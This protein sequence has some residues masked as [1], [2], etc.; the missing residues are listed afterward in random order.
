MLIG[1]QAIVLHTF[2]YGDSS[3]VARMYTRQR[4]LVSFLINGVRSKKGGNKAALLQPLS[5]LE[6][7]MQLK[8]NRGLQNIRELRIDVPYSGIP[9]SSGKTAQALF[10]AEVLL[11]TIKEEE[12]NDDLFDFL[13]DALLLL[14]QTPQ[15]L[16]DF[17]L[18][19]LLEFSRFLGFYPSDNFSQDTP[20]FQFTDGVF[21]HSPGPTCLDGPSSEAIHQLLSIGF[22]QLH[23]LKFSRP[24]RR[25]IS[26]H[27]L[28]FF[29]W[30]LPSIHGLHTPEVLEEVFG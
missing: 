20:Y 7:Q 8:E 3:V 2:R 21:H 12:S 6:I 4:G 29:R 1:S 25:M 14:D 17:H 5:L 24:M 30:H 16:P 18:K 26:R 10:L 27:L 9:F 11:R 19:F 22:G 15:E 23:T 28:E 13:R